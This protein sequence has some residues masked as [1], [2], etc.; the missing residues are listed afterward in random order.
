MKAIR[1]KTYTDPNIMSRAEFDSL[2]EQS[3]TLQK[4]VDLL[5]SKLENALLV[6][7]DFASS[8]NGLSKVGQS[9]FA[10]LFSGQKNN[11]EGNNIHNSEGSA[12]KKRKFGEISK[13]STSSPIPELPL[14]KKLSTPL[15]IQR[16][17]T[18]DMLTFLDDIN[19]V[20][21]ADGSL[22]V[23]VPTANVATPSN[24]FTLPRRLDTSPRP[25]SLRTLDLPLCRSESTIRKAL[26][27]MFSSSSVSKVQDDSL[28]LDL[29]VENKDK[30]NNRMEGAVSPSQSFDAMCISGGEKSNEPVL[31]SAKSCAAIASRAASG[32]CE[33][34]ELAAAAASAATLSESLQTA[35]AKAV[36]DGGKALPEPT[37]EAVA[38]LMSLV[39]PQVQMVL[40]AQLKAASGLA[41]F[42]LKPVESSV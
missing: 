15:P 33:A 13:T 6:I 40:L 18:Q 9:A 5:E 27:T 23:S 24:G 31:L 26:P 2:R 28:S 30:S 38:D 42:T 32:A 34:A 4:K 8:R 39:L 20:D 16:S 22:K 3:D 10:A 7:A 29:G 37:P 41:S 17:T 11:S 21:S 1:R 25:G 35:V 19:F 36:K 12:A 14:G